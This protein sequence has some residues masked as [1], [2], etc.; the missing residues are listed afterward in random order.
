MDPLTGLPTLRHDLHIDRGMAYEAAVARLEHE[1]AGGA[2]L[3][4]GVLELQHMQRLAQLPPG[5]SAAALFATHPATHPRNTCPSPSPPPAGPQ[6]RSGFFVSRRPMFGKSLVLLALQKPGAHNVFAICRPNTGAGAGARGAGLCRTAPQQQLRGCLLGRR[7]AAPKCVRSPA[8]LAAHLRLRLLHA[9]PPGPSYFD[10]EL[11]EL[12]GKYTAITGG[13]LSLGRS[14]WLGR[15]GGSAG[16][17]RAVRSLQRACSGPTQRR[18]WCPPP[19]PLTSRPA[20][21]CAAP[22]PSCSGGGAGGVGSPVRGLLARLHARLAL[23]G[24]GHLPGGGG[25]APAPPPSLHFKPALHVS[26]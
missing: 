17:R 5:A 7:A 22:L 26:G 10:M 11:E 19:G 8:S 15:C 25:A 6:D 9:P 24:G 4:A 23:Q 14:W 2:C 12:T 1:R 16:P 13:A 3:G 20:L 21:A 18:S